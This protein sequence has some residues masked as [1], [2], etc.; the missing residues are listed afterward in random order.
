MA[1]GIAAA[2]LVLQV[3]ASKDA[4]IQAKKERRAQRR[5][6]Q[7]RAARARRRQLAA[8][9][10][11]RAELRN[12]EGVQGVSTSSTATASSAI[13]S[14]LASNLSFINAQDALSETAFV[15][16]SRRASAEGNAATFSAIG[17]I[18][19]NFAQRG[20]NAASE[21]IFVDG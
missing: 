18:A 20:G 1:V 8:A 10:A 3:G 16:S 5:L 13:Q 12:Q 19:G 11:R 15:A 2:A 17:G 21:D 7:L 4:A 9:R 6:E 14:Q